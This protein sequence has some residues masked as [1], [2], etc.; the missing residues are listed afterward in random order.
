MD[1]QHKE[2]WIEE[3]LDSTS[4][5]MPATPQRELYAGI[6]ARLDRKVT[7]AGRTIPMRVVYAAAACFVVLLGLNLLTILRKPAVQQGGMNEVIEYYQLNDNGIG[8]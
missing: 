3:V 1:R 4:G 7:I 8:I 6:R 5:M 2:Q